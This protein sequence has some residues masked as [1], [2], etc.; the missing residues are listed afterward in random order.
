MQLYLRQPI[1]SISRPVRQLK[2]FDKIAL[3]AGESRRIELSVPTR[4]LGYHDAQG[5]TIIEPGRFEVFVG[6]SS[7]ADV[8][9]EFILAAKRSVVVRP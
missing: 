6:N 1:A 3:K 5:R 4:D 9:G 7:L 2:S 8:K